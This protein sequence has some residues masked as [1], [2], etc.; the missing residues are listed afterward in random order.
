MRVATLVMVKLE[1]VAVCIDAVEARSD[2]CARGTCAKHVGREWDVHTDRE[3]THREPWRCSWFGHIAPACPVGS[4]W[5]V[6]A[7]GGRGNFRAAIRIRPGKRL[8]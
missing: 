5:S 3:R 1:A 6:E 2:R 8:T 7:L 4:G